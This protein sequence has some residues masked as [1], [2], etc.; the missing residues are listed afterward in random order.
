MLAVATPE[1]RGAH[2]RQPLLRRSPQL[3]DEHVGGAG[4]AQCGESQLDVAVPQ[5][6][7][8]AAKQLGD[9]AHDDSGPVPRLAQRGP[10]HDGRRDECHRPADQR[11]GPAQERIPRSGGQRSHHDP[12][13]GGLDDQQLSRVEQQRDRHAGRDDQRDLQ[14]PGADEVRG[15]VAEQHAEGD[16]DGDLGDPALALAVGHAERH[17]SRDG[18]EERQ[19]V[20]EDVRRQ[21]PRHA[22]GDRALA[23]HPALGPQPLDPRAQRHTPASGQHLRVEAHG[24][25]ALRVPTRRCAPGC[26]GSPRTG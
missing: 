14:A 8:G 22:G 4:I 18:R 1:G 6:V 11:V 7:R 15:H 2:H 23:D 24:R 20:V 19:T 3:G 9:L 26:A 16:P 10:R 12:L 21:P 17:D 5:P 13:D 25:A